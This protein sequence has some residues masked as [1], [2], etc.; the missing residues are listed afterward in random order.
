MEERDEVIKLF[1]KEE[2]KPKERSAFN[3][4]FSVSHQGVSLLDNFQL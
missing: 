3:S 4:P 1:L 2:D